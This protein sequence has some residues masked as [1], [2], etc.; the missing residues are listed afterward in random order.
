MQNAKCIETPVA[1]L[2]LLLEQARRDGIAAASGSLT[3]CARA[4]N[5][6]RAWANELRATRGAA[7]YRA[8]VT[9]YVAGKSS[10]VLS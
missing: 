5:T 8:A 9:A 7:V 10:A 1:V 4:D 6:F 2:A 3:D